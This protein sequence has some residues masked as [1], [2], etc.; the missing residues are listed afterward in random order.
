MGW[1]WL[2]LNPPPCS[3]RKSL[4][5]KNVVLSAVLPAGDVLPHLA[6]LLKVSCPAVEEMQ[7]VQI[8]GNSSVDSSYAGEDDA[9]ACLSFN[10]LHPAVCGHHA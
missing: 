6:S 5:P 3:N 2:D 10:K 9:A 4:S 8:T 1:R 7:P